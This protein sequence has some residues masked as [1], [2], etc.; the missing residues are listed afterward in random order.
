[1][2]ARI[3]DMREFCEMYETFEHEWR[4]SSL[5]NARA[6]KHEVLINTRF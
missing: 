5:C 1:M 6:G 4:L 3:E 2:V